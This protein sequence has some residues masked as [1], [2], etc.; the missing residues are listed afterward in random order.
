V[1][2]RILELYSQFQ[3]LGIRD[4]T[5]K[6]FPDSRIRILLNEGVHCGP[7]IRQKQ[8]KQLAEI[9]ITLDYESE[10]V[11]SNGGIYSLFQGFSLQERRKLMKSEPEK[12]SRCVWRRARNFSLFFSLLLVHCCF[13]SRSTFASCKEIRILEY[14]K[15]LLVESGILGLGTRNTAKGIR[16]STDEWNLESKLHRQRLEPITWESRAMVWNPRIQDCLGSPYIGRLL[17]ATLQL[18]LH[19]LNAARLQQP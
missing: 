13:P 10:P 12:T 5:S 17:R 6:N 18:T 16:N 8:Q 19:C 3:T 9:N 1:G 2:Y 4:S 15:F 14:K 11:T 7:Q